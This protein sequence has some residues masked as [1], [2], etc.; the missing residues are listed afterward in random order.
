MLGPLVALVPLRQVRRG[1]GPQGQRRALWAICIADGKQLLRRLA[2]RGP[3][4]KLT[5]GKG[6]GQCWVRQVL[7]PL[8]ERLSATLVS[9]LW[10]PTRTMNLSGWLTNCYLAGVRGSAG[11][12]KDSGSIS[13]LIR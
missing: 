4:L 11:K 9:A 10:V 5:G 12:F 6:P 2:L 3:V 13:A 1:R 8:K 7:L